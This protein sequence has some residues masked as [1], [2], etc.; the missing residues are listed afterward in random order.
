VLNLYLTAQISE[1]SLLCNRC[2]KTPDMT[3]H[4]FSVFLKRSTGCYGRASCCGRIHDQ[5]IFKNTE[6]LPGYPKNKRFA[7]N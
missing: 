7:L 4:T 1:Y 3:R 2:V 5:S 6:Y